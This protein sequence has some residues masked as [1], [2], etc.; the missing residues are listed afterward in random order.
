ML[1]ILHKCFHSDLHDG[2]FAK[3]MESKGPFLSAQV[4]FLQWLYT[5]LSFKPYLGNVP[6]FPC[7][8][9]FKPFP[10]CLKFIWI[11]FMDADIYF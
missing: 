10:Y 3:G 7:K 5:E 1:W 6:N 8:E 4:G 2:T 11:V 9:N